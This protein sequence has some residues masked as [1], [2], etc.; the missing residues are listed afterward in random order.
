MRAKER[1][2]TD[3]VAAMEAAIKRRSTGSDIDFSSVELLEASKYG[4]ISHCESLLSEGADLS[5][6]DEVG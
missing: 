6:K 4:S 5:C 2:Q 3:T 1:N